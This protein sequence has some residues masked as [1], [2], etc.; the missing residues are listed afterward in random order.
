MFISVKLGSVG[1]FF[2]SL[3]SKLAYGPTVADII[4]HSSL[5]SSS[6]C[7]HVSLNFT[8]EKKLKVVKKKK[9]PTK[10]RT[11]IGQLSDQPAITMGTLRLSF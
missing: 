5:L 6:H 8:Q 4:Q 7:G 2:F 11:Q 9:K 10:K 3:F 1:V